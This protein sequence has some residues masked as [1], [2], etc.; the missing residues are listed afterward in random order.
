MFEQ[1]FSSHAMLLQ[2]AR[3]HG[4]R[5]LVLLGGTQATNERA[6][7]FYRKLG[8]RTVGTFEHPRG[9]QNYDMLLEL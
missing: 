6:M 4:R 2:V 8:F 9:A 3:E 5:R 7:H 1:V